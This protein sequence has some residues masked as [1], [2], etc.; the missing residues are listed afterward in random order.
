MKNFILKLLILLLFSQAGR[1]QITT[2]SIKKVGTLPLKNLI[3]PIS[4]EKVAMAKT[5]SLT[6][7]VEE[8]TCPCMTGCSV[9]PV[10]ILLFEGKRINTEQVMLYWKTT[11][12][13]QNKGFDVE[14]STTAIN[15]FRKITFVP[16]LQNNY[17]TK[18]YE[19]PDN[20]NFSGPSFYRLKQWDLD[21]NFHYSEIIKIEG[22]AL[23]P[24]LRLFPNPT[25]SQL[26]VEMFFLKKG[27]VKLKMLNAT[28]QVLLTKDV[29]VN[30]GFNNIHL[31]V[32]SLAAGLYFVKILSDDEEVL[33][34]KFIKL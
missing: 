15:G 34:E 27:K 6:E 14:R 24:L 4:F 1:A 30:A 2:P 33:I 26:T 23:N 32:S 9:V 29:Q 8:N 28:Q 25:A 19:L 7:A 18:N 22:Y 5:G 20:N 17:L 3:V 12:E 13:F 16:S 21:G 11:N 31:P 10:N